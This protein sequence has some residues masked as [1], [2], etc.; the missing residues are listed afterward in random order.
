M[1]ILCSR[2]I[3]LHRN[4]VSTI[5]LKNY[6]TLRKF[7][8]V[9]NQKRD[10]A[11]LQVEA[12]YSKPKVCPYVVFRYNVIFTAI[13]IINTIMLPYYNHVIII[14]HNIAFNDV[15]LTA[16]CAAVIVIDRHATLDKAPVLYEEIPWLWQLC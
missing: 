15:M 3:Q 11:A 12:G 9:R 2:L 1:L 6:Y 4:K 5:L 7:F 10:R 16:N 14:T 13:S 8:Q